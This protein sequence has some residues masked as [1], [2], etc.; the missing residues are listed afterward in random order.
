MDIL[1]PNIHQRHL[2]L[3]VQVGTPVAHFSA[4]LQSLDSNHRLFALV[5]YRKRLLLKLMFIKSRRKRMEGSKSK[6]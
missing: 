3:N 2:I 4:T 1:G 5:V 6:R